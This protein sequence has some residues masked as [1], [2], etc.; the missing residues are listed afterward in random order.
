MQTIMT[1]GLDIAKSVFQFHG[2]DAGG[3]G[4][5]PPPVEAS[6]GAGVLSEAA[7]M[8]GWHRG[9]TCRSGRLMSAF[10]GE[11]DIAA[12]TGSSSR[13]AGS[14]PSLCRRARQRVHRQP[15][16]AMSQDGA[17][18]CQAESVFYDGQNRGQLS[19]DV[20]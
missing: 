2:V 6:P 5:H 20:R 14:S 1:I 13:T 19:R 8:P 4:D 11:T 16:C 17:V 18:F 10:G 9:R 7:A 3:Q 15:H 12:I